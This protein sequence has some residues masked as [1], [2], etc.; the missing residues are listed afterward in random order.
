MQ[1]FFRQWASTAA[2]AAAVLLPQVQAST[3]ID[4]EG[5]TGLYFPGDSFV[6]A[7]YRM[8][9]I[10]DF[11]T[12]DTAAA[13]GA[14]APTGN[15]TEF[16][17]NSNEGGLLVERADGGKFNLDGFS[18]AFVPLDPAPSP[19][20][21]IVLIADVG[22]YGYYFDLGDT[23]ADKNHPFLTYSGLGGYF[24]EVSYVLFYGCVLSSS[25]V[26]VD[27]TNNNAQFAIDNIGVTAVPEPTTVALM[28]L[29]LA[30]LALRARRGLC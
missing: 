22:L 28:A 2:V 20:Q 27:P 17:F 10:G 6:Q 4:F 24:P 18:A 30:G 29:G 9:A 21:R 26:C 11:G 12:V 16:Y 25:G 23:T 3:L 7:G 14:V 5:S 13:L 15:T 8:T 19:A 1:K